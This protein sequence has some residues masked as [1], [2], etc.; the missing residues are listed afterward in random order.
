MSNGLTYP[1]FSGYGGTGGGGGGGGAPAN[2]TYLTLSLDGT[3]TDERVFTPSARFSAVDGGAGSTY[4]LDLN[5]SGVVAGSYTY[6][7]ITVDAYGRV[8]S[9][10]NGTDPAPS[11][12]QYLTLALNGTLSDERQFSPSARFAATD[13]G[14]GGTYALDLAVTGVVAGSYTIT[15]LTVDAYGRITAA[16]SGTIASGAGWTDGGTN[17]YLSVDTD[18]VSMGNVTP[19]P[20]RKLSV[21]NTG[22][23]L[24]ISVVTLASTDN[25]IS[26]FV[27]GEA[28]LRFSV[29]GTGSHSWGAGGASAPDTRM[30]RSG[31]NTLSFDN[32]LGTAAANLLPGVD[33]GGVIGTNT[34][35]WGSVIS[36]IFSAYGA[37]GAANPVTSLSTTGLRFGPG[38]GV[39]LDTRIARTAASTL[40]VDNNAG[41][42]AIFSVLGQT[43]TQTRALA[44]TTQ[45]SAYAVASTADVVLVNPSGGA[46]DVTLPNANLIV[47]RRVQV[48][49]INTS[50][51]VVT[52]K[53]AGG[54][55]DNVA[56]ATGIAL[57]GG[58]YNSIT[59]VS[60]GANWWII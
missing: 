21:F 6:A 38:G 31:V 34:F 53:S 44:V 26:T 22:T 8:T 13:G 9:A 17:V 54:T 42:S 16:S 19:V 47:G 15:S 25:V 40:T 5:V 20:F 41:G 57:A 46:F 49:R 58:T 1:P 10:A 48:K 37:A 45:T 43:T 56:A 35:R 4:A 27:S 32:A 3:L 36:N 39:A 28:N 7:A 2:A 11:T 60:D 51:N 59:V 50:A 52:V 23:N 18:V 30:Y 33:G 14:A 29:N 12:A 55:I 24:G